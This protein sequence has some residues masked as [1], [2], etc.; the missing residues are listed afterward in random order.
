MD[1]KELTWDYTSQCMLRH[2]PNGKNQQQEDA[3]RYIYTVKELHAQSIKFVRLPYSTKTYA[4]WK[5]KLWQE[6]STYSNKFSREIQDQQFDTC[7]KDSIRYSGINL[8]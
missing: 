1:Y 5:K 2:L 6:P 7:P 8:D 3:H 4:K